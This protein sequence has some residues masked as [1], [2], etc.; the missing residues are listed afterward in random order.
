MFISKT[1]HKGII[2]Y[3]LLIFIIL[4]GFITR[5]YKN[6]QHPA[7]FFCDEAG[8]T[9][10]AYH[11]ATSGKDSQGNILP[12]YFTV[13]SP[14]G[15]VAIYDQVPLIWLFGMNEF[16]SR[17]TSALIGTFTIGIVFFLTKEF[18]QNYEIA[19]FAAFLTAISPWHIQFSRFGTENIRLPFYFS[20][21]LLLFVLGIRKQKNIYIFLSTVFL[22]LGFYAYTAAAVFI[23]PFILG[24][25]VI[26]KKYFLKNKLIT[27]GLV[28]LV[29]LYSLPF[30]YQMIRFPQ[31]SRFAEV[32]VFKEK[33]T[34]EAV[35]QM[36]RTYSESYSSDFLFLKG[37][38][39]MPEHFINRFSV[40][41]FGELYLVAL[42]LFLAGLYYLSK[43]IKKK[44][45]Q[46][47][48][49]WFLLYP[50]GSVVAGADGGGPFA[51]RSIIGVLIFQI[52]TSVG[53]IYIISLIRDIQL[54]IAIF[55]SITLLFII[56]FSLYIYTYFV[57]YSLYSEDF[58]GWQYG[59]KDIIRYFIK[60][61][62]NYND[63]IMIPEFNA[64]DIFFKFYAPADCKKCKLGQPDD[65]LD[66]TRKQLF[67]VTLLYLQQHPSFKM[68]IQKI[69][70]YPNGKPAFLIGEI[71][72][73]P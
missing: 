39:G 56:S 52:I 3:L 11:I 17:I 64:P 6:T 32:S 63:E 41:G 44:E 73:S 42:P 69:I 45:N 22:F 15:P 36:I 72:K 35:E 16:T 58:W 51:T 70:F 33:T 12:F 10:E 27:L 47:L 53:F 1:L 68:D 24:L 37:D 61:Q 18:F 67:A 48:L 29:I 4:S 26:Y 25:A 57:S 59:A 43:N 14:R 23:F 49:L 50:L 5:V 13:F 54:R 46:V 28:F 7:G 55:I 30:M 66:L 40:K 38:A 21:F 19:I 9:Y 60:Q 8:L 20:L 2:I 62:E 31:Q 34:I 71:K 65:S